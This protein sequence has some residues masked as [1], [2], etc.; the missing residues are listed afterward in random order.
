MKEATSLIAESVTSKAA[1][2]EMTAAVR[3]IIQLAAI[4]IVSLINENIGAKITV[5]YGKMAISS[6]HMAAAIRHAALDVIILGNMAITVRLQDAPKAMA[7]EI[8]GFRSSKM[9]IPN[10]FIRNGKYQWKCPNRFFR[11]GWR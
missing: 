7:K 5:N 8:N 1:I 6:S 9:P 10:W 3:G 4:N 11:F 2:Q